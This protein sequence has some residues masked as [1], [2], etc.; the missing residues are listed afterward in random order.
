MF[1]SFLPEIERYSCRIWC[2]RDTGVADYMGVLP[3]G[4]E[5]Y[6][7]GEPANKFC[8]KGSCM[9]FD[10]QGNSIQVHRK[11]RPEEW[12]KTLFIKHMYI[13]LHLLNISRSNNRVC[14]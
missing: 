13:D 5:C 8:V 7:P 11:P 4:A 3:D 14:L 1:C 2:R 6:A 12:S 10:C 9:R